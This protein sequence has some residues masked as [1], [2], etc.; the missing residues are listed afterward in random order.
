MEKYN[1]P[2]RETPF[3]ESEP[4][5]DEVSLLSRRSLILVQV[6]LNLVENLLQAGTCCPLKLHFMLNYDLYNCKKFS[7]WVFLRDRQGKIEG[8]APVLDSVIP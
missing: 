1:F 5:T 8:A 3:T 7:R 6:A 2:A 4:L